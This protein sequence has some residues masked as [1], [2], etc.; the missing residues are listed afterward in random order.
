MT[1]VKKIIL[2]VLLATVW[3]SISEF[4]RN[5]FIFK[6]WWIEHY[7]KMGLT[8]PAEPINGAAWGF[9]ALLFSIAIFIISRK[10]TFW[11]TIFL[12]WLI[13]FVLMWIAIGN[14]AV[15]PY[16]LLVYAVPWS[17][18]AVIVAVWIINLKYFK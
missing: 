5:Q 9:W 2:P 12:S 1:T 7:Q 11:Q 8:F 14:L 3:I 13:G 4:T 15:L 10:F 6:S 16:G 18:I 17:L